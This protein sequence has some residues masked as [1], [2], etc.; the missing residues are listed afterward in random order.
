MKTPIGVIR[1]YAEGMQDETDEEK[2]Q[3]YSEVIISETERM[4]VL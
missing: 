4:S 2:R 3:K 1:A